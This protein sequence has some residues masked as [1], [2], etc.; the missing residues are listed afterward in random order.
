MEILLICLDFA[1]ISAEIYLL[2]RLSLTRDPFFQI[3]FFH[4]LTVTGIGGIISVCGY[5]IN[6]RFQVT[7]ESAWSFKFGYVLNSFGV[8]LSTTGKLC[9]VVNRFVAMRNGMLLENVFTIS[10]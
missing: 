10:K 6:V 5:L 3:P 9:I 4:F 7:E 2:F 1:L 8:T